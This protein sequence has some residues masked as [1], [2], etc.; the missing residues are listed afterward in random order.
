MNDE[1]LKQQFVHAMYDYY[2]IENDSELM[3][4][5]DIYNS[6]VAPLITRKLKEA[7]RV[8]FMKCWS[9]TYDFLHSNQKDLLDE[10]EVLTELE[11]ESTDER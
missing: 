9:I 5:A 4:Y 10:W 2:G 7:E 8:G 1:E 11:K 6:V 3:Y